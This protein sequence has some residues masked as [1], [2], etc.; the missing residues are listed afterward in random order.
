MTER[1]SIGRCAELSTF[2]KSAEGRMLHVL[3]TPIV[4]KGAH[5]HVTGSSL[6]TVL[7][8]FLP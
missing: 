6:C 7:Y 5:K 3:R 1:A 2:I 4:L 8:T